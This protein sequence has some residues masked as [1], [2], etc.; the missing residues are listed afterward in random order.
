MTSQRHPIRVGISGWVYPA[1]RGTFYPTGLRQR[2]ELAYAA[3]RLDTIEINGTFYSLQRP[4]SFARWRD[5]VPAEFRFAVKGH[6]FATHFARLKNAAPTIADF[7]ASG[8]LALGER[9]GPVLWQT[10]PNLQFDAEVLDTFLGQLPHTTDAARRLIA[11]H[12]RLEGDRRSVPTRGDHRIRHALEVRHESFLDPSFGAL[13]RKHNVAAVVAD[14]AGRYPHI[15][16]ITAS[17]VYVRLHGDRELY[18]SGYSDRALRTWADAIRG[19]ADG[20]GCPDGKGRD[21]H[22]FF[23]NDTKVRAPFDAMRLRTLLAER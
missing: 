20:S 3:E 8:V 1:W 22:V 4:S 23:D 7:L 10:P 19:W 21:V 13:L 9:L 11:E 5:S 14:T 15:R 2:D 16:E 6:R 17:H 12:G 18:A